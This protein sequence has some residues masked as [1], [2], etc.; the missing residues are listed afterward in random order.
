MFGC[1]ISRNIS[2]SRSKVC[3]SVVVEFWE[4]LDIGTCSMFLKESNELVK[5]SWGLL[6]KS[7]QPMLSLFS[8]GTF[9]RHPKHFGQKKWCCR[10]LWS[11][12]C[13]VAPKFL[14]CTRVASFWWNWPCL[15]VIAELLRWH[16]SQ[17]LLSCCQ[18]LY[19]WLRVECQAP[20]KQKVHAICIFNEKCC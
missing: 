18:E 16:N 6:K 8:A 10:L 13:D 5:Q 12:V 15:V 4:L 20:A 19:S 17:R 2:F 11:W 14:V 9:A 1:V 3:N 7:W